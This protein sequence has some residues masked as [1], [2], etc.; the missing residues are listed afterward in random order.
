MSR[1]IGE[2]LRFTATASSTAPPEVVYDA[3]TDLASHV[4]WGGP[5]SAS[6]SQHLLD[7][8]ARPGPVVAGTTF[9]STGA[10][11]KD[12]FHDT[13]Q[14]TE[15]VSPSR[16][17]FRTDARMARRHGREWLAEFTHEYLI[18]PTAQGSLISYSCRVRPK[19]YLPYW[20]FPGLKLATKVAVT[21]IMRKNLAG[22]ARSAQV[23]VPS[24]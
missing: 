12:V 6:K 21:G 2:R 3:L 10:A 7:I 16:F 14:V 18:E 17:S 8:D 9:T 15:A 1:E 23:R 4:Q 11:G 20:L 5:G 19:N 24:S 22:L 13:S